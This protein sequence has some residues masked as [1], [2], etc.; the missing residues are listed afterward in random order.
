MSNFTG[1]IRIQLSTKITKR[2]QLLT[3]RLRHQ[4]MKHQQI[5]QGH[6]QIGY[7]YGNNIDRK[8]NSTKKKEK[9]S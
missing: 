1:K 9:N 6:K 3:R 4:K 8:L 7:V 5:F 2:K